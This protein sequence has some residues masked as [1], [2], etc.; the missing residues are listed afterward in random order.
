MKTPEYLG[1]YKI[2]KIGNT[3]M[4]TIPVSFVKA[5]GLIGGKNGD[6]MVICRAGRTLI[7]EKAGDEDGKERKTD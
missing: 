1:K 6:K 2:Q 5:V 4:V 7:M 3:L